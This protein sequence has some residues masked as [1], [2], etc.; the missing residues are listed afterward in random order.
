MNI[1]KYIITSLLVFGITIPVNAYELCTPTKEY[2][3]YQKLSSEEKS[4]YQ[5]PVFCS[6][7]VNNKKQDSFL[8][9]SLYSKLYSS[10]SDS[11]YNSYTSGIATAPKNQD[12]TGLCWDFASISTVEANDEKK[13]LGTFDFSE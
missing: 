10:A 13:G 4:K 1:K 2:N 6:E 12:A 9:S 3:D 11:S 8:R 7:I 5:A